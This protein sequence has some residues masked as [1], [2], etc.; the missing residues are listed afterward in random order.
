[1]ED[2][3]NLNR[4]IFVKVPFAFGAYRFK[5]LRSQPWGAVDLMILQALMDGPSSSHT[6]ASRSGLPRQLI[7]EILIPLMRAGWVEISNSDSEFRFLITDRG[8][9][10]SGGDELPANQEPLSHFRSFLVDP[11]TGQCYVSAP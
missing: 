8:R 2:K 3:S 6:L 7:V 10:V 5:I 4:K 1:M 11:I 9:A